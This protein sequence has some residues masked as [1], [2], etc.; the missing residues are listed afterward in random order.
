MVLVFRQSFENRSKDTK[1]I[2]KV[3]VSKVFLN[4]T[5]WLLSLISMSISLFLKSQKAFLLTLDL[6]RQISADLNKAKDVL[7]LLF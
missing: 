7:A 6:L 1:S 4:I 3:T 5:L 2:Y